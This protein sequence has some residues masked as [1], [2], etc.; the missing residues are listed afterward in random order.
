M[1]QHSREVIAELLGLDAATIDAL[2]TRE[3]VHDERA[4]VE[5]G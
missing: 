1:G 4:P 3:V 2:V 5:L